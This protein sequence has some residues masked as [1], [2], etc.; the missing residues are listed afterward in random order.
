MNPTAEQRTAIET[1]DRALIVEAGAGT[2]KTW[3]L[4]RRFMHLL[5]THPDWQLESVTAITFTEKAAREM[6][7]RLRTAIEDKARD[8]PKAAYWQAHRLNLDRLQV[9]TIHSLCARI[10]RENS[11]AAG[12]DPRFQVLD[13]QEADLLKE[14][15]VQETFKTL[16]EED[17]AA[18]ELLTS[19]RI[20]DLRAELETILSKRGTLRQLFEDPGEPETLVERWKTGIEEMRQGLW[21]AHLHENPEMPDICAEILLIPIQ[22]PTDKLA[23]AVQAAQRGAAAAGQGDFLDAVNQWLTIKRSGGRADNWGGAERKTYLSTELL[24][25]LQDA[26]KSLEKRGFLQEISHMDLAAAQHLQL[27]KWL[28][29]LL[30]STYTEIKESQ[31]ALD[32]DDLE[33]LTEHLLQQTPRTVRLQNYLSSINHLM[34]DEFQ[35]TNLVQQRIV[36]ALAP[37]DDPGK[38]FVVGD[39]KQSIYRF[40]QAQVSVFSHTASDIEAVTGKPAERLSTSFRTHHSLVQAANHLFNQLLLPM[41]DEHADFEAS[42][43]PLKAQRDQ[44]ELTSPVEMLILP[45]YDTQDQRI[46][47]EDARRWEAQWIARRLLQ[48]KESEFPTWDKQMGAYRPFEFKDAAV[49]FRATTQMP[50]YETEFKN[51]GLPYLTVSGRGYYDRS[52]VQDLLA[53]LA[54]LANPSDNLNLAACLRSPLF[55]LNDETLYQL[56][57]HTPDGAF[58]PAPIS[59][60]TALSQPA[61]TDQG[62]YVARAHGILEHLWGL[63]GRVDVWSLLRAALDATG[64]ETTLAL[65]DGETGRQRANVNKF[66]SLARER[67]GVSVAGFLRRIRELK[68]R[69]A[70]EGEALG[71]EPESGA[72]QL[73]SIHASKG[74]EFPVVTVAD[75]GR[76]KGGGFGSAYLLHDPAFGLVCKVRDEYGDWQKPAGY[77]WGEWL[78]ERMEQAED[79]RLLY[80]ASTRAADLLIFSGQVGNKNS[81]LAEALDAWNIEAAGAEAEE[82]NCGEF[83]IRLSRPAEPEALPQTAVHSRREALRLEA[84]PI[85][86]APLPLSA[87]AQPAAMTHLA[88]LLTRAEPDSQDLQTALWISQRGESSTRAPGYLIGN[89]L[90]RVL[91]H[92]DCLGYSEGDLLRL[93]ENYARREG[94]FNHTLAD[95]VQRSYQMVTNFKKHEIYL[96]IQHARQRFHELTV[97][98]SEDVGVLHG[99]IDLLYQDQSGNWHLIDWKTE[100]APKSEI[101]E[102][103]QQYLVQMAAYARAIYKNLHTQPRAQL[104]FLNPAVELYR[105]TDES[106]TNAWGEVSTAMG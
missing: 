70:R 11:I 24:K 46:S 68:A 34:V 81:W 57:W 16:E 45:K 12:I 65:N 55:S 83:S 2:G 99:V 90:H 4:V 26:A 36:Y 61:N 19:L 40:R 106:I 20:F 96:E 6:R 8:N 23:P 104:C 93:L 21:Q 103:A 50:L 44:P 74:L 77:A 14:Q 75:M 9:S 53:L 84:V 88:Q 59:M 15:A 37:I 78:E 35:D 31:Q 62:E 94:V 101:E 54:A 92:W 38:L 43:G 56:R 3:V 49:L 42:P 95:A 79:K 105:F 64:Y 48:L 82:C 80:V 69:E 1:Q 60:R 85:L 73:M 97:L 86:A 100:W 58:A 13:E 32:F 71:R 18:L 7:T 72:V 33:L 98:L 5:E 27:W 67:G 87:H 17:H 41:G 51:A 28:W 39:A 25:P 89:I 76:K 29:E 63:A 102:N 52:E 10:L 47:A 30:D 66:L 91:A 22:D